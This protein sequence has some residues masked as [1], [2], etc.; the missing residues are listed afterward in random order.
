MN[1][2]R[3]KYREILKQVDRWLA[4]DNQ[5]KQA[6]NDFMAVVAPDSEVYAN[7][8]TGLKGFFEGIALFH[9][10]LIEGLEYY[11]YEMPSMKNPSGRIG[12]KVYDFTDIEQFIDFEMARDK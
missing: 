5:I 1:M 8:T 12:D 10:E 9:P 2:T 11:A 7:E 3:D 6:Y 4:I